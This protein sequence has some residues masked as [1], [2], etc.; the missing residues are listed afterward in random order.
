MGNYRPISLSLISVK[1]LEQLN[2]ETISKL[3]KDKKVIGNSQ[4]RFMKKKTCLTNLVAFFFAL[5]IVLMDKGRAVEV[6]SLCF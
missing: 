2:L 1:V 3:V 6:F 4:H 5:M